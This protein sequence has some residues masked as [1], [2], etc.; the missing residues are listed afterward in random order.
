MDGN[1]Y[2]VS[3]LNARY[4]S[5]SDRQM[6]WNELRQAG[7]EATGTLSN[8]I[9]AE[10]RTIPAWQF[11]GTQPTPPTAT[12]VVQQ[13][14]VTPSPTRIAATASPTVAA[15]QTIRPTNTPTTPQSQPTATVAASTAPYYGAPLAIPGRIEAEDFNRGT[16]GTAY[17]DT[18]SGMEGGNIYRQDIVDV[19]LKSNA[20]GTHTLGWFINGEWTAYTVNVAQVGSYDITIHGGSVEPRRMLSILFNGQPTASNI[21]MPTVANWDTHEV[22]VV[23]GVQLNAGIQEM[24]LV[25]TL[26]FLDVDYVEFTLAGSAQVPTVAA[27]AT[28]Q[29]TSVPAT[30]VPTQP[31]VRA[32]S[33]V[34]SVQPNSSVTVDFFL[35]MPQQLP[36]GGA[37]AL[38]AVC[39]LSPANIAIGTNVTAG[40]LFGA[41]ALVVNAGFRPDNSF[42]FATSQTNAASLVTTGGVA[43]STTVNTLAAGQAT[44]QCNVSVIN[45]NRVETQLPFTALTLNVGGQAS[46]AAPPTTAP[47]SPTPTQVPPT[48]VPPTATVAPPTPTSAPQNGGVRGTVLR[49][50]AAPAS[51]TITLLT[52]GQSVA[53][54]STS[55]TGTF[56][57]TNVAPGTYTIRASSPGHLPGEGSVTIVAGQTIEK[58]PLILLA[59]DLVAST[60][61]V[62]D[63]LDVVQLAVAY[64]TTTTGRA[65]AGDLDENGRIGL[66]DLV[67]IAENLRRTGPIAWN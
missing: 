12:Q 51:T 47:A 15:T 58:A 46:T 31:A 67:A 29:P 43:F 19:D 54:T 40:S 1:T 16:N 53:T 25:S 64:G 48:A 36:G 8:N 27:T 11:R 30:S 41:D 63:E 39:T 14:S 45:G 61:P 57:L 59:G 3:D 52:N 9:P 20:Y 37:R 2:L 5:W 62:I 28:P 10:M 23:R 42:I 44:L 26:G 38:E 33:Q 56:E 17:S 50:H 13:P 22:T 65:A 6:T 32:V 18:T 34:P 66:G 55:N 24:R 7:Q 49:S 4:W 35:D 21:L 60:T